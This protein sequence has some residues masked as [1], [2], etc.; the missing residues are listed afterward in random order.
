MK[1][2]RT[3]MGCQWPSVAAEEVLEHAKL[4]GLR[5]ETCAIEAGI[6]ASGAWRNDPVKGQAALA[7]WKSTA[8]SSKSW[9]R[10]PK[11][12]TS[13]S[14]SHAREAIKVGNNDLRLFMSSLWLPHVFIQTQQKGKNGRPTKILRFQKPGQRWSEDTHIDW[15]FNRW[16]ISS[17][18]Y[19]MQDNSDRTH[20]R[21][22]L[23][24]SPPAGYH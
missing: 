12:K 21:E 4:E 22:T 17:E 5:R 2:K 24:T 20:E 1:A 16:E 23:N 6:L 7:V 9:N 3:R 18:E 8:G 15:K 10:S 19:D 14:Q 11:I 13:Q